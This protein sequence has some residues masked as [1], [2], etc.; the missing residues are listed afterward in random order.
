MA[1]YM[2]DTNLKVVHHL[3]DKKKEC[4]IFYIEKKHRQYFT[5]DVLE[6]AKN[7]GF[8]PCKFCI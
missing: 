8:M 4:K 7:Q 1:G 6:Q 3:A 2:G 5:P